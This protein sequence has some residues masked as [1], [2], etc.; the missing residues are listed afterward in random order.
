MP[1]HSGAWGTRVKVIILAQAANI[2]SV[3]SGVKVGTRVG[4]RIGIGTSIGYQV[5]GGAE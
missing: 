3:W 1:Y 5:S 4:I 2:V